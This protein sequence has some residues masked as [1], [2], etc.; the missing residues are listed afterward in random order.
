MKSQAVICLRW[1]G[2]PGQQLWRVIDD[3]FSSPHCTSLCYLGMTSHGSTG[4][5]YGSLLSTKHTLG[6]SCLCVAGDDEREEEWS[7]GVPLGRSS[8]V[9]TLC[10]P[11]RVVNDH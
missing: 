8:R 10:A 11:L 4:G 7:E 3:G 9:S 5:L 2:L 1:G 6:T